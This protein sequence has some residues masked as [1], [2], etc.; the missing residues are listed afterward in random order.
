LGE[1]DFEQVGDLGVIVHDEDAG[2]GS[3]GG[4]SS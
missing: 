4:H 2:D 3:R 1:K